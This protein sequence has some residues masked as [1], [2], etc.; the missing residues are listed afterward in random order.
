MDF[1]QF[2]EHANRL[3]ASNPIW[4]ALDADPVG[5]K[6]EIKIVEKQLNVSLPE[7]YK[8][9]IEAFGGGYFAFTVIFS[10]SADSEWNIANQNQSIGLLEKQHFLAVSDNQAGDYYGYIIE[11]GLSEKNLFVMTMITAKLNERST[12]ISLNI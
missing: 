2:N 3:K 6:A 12:E 5:I 7:D 10:V 8:E 1:N 4:F 9:F 11:N